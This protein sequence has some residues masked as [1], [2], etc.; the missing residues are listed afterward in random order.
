MRCGGGYW[1]I[2]SYTKE[3]R[4]YDESAD[5]G[6]YDKEMAQKAFDAK[7]VTFAEEMDYHELDIERIVLD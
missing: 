4:L 1:R 3:L 7:R 2:N 5:F 6:K